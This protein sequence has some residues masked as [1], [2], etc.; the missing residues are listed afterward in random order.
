[1]GEWNTVVPRFRRRAAACYPLRTRATLKLT[2][3]KYFPCLVTDMPDNDDSSDDSMV[4]ALSDAVTTAGGTSSGTDA[5]E[6]PFIERNTPNPVE[7][8]G[9]EGVEKLYPASRGASTPNASDWMA[10]T[11]IQAKANIV[12]FTEH[13]EHFYPPCTWDFMTNEMSWHT[14][15][16]TTEE[17]RKCG[18]RYCSQDREVPFLQAY[19]ALF[20]AKSLALECNTL[21]PKRPRTCGQEFRW[22]V[23]W[24][25]KRAYLYNDHII[26]G[27]INDVQWE[28]SF[29][30]RGSAVPYT[31]KECITSLAERWHCYWH[32]GDVPSKS[33]V[34]DLTEIDTTPICND[35][36]SERARK[37]R[38][39][40]QSRHVSRGG[41]ALRRR[42]QDD[43]QWQVFPLLLKPAPLDEDYVPCLRTSLASR[44]ACAVTSLR[45][46]VSAVAQNTNTNE[47]I[48]QYPDNP[49]RGQEPKVKVEPRDEDVHAIVPSV[50]EVIPIAEP[51]KED[52]FIDLEDE[53]ES[54]ES[55]EIKHGAHNQLQQA[56]LQENVKPLTHRLVDGYNAEIDVGPYHMITEQ[57]DDPADDPRG[58]NDPGGGRNQPLNM[59]RNQFGNHVADTDSEYAKAKEMSCQKRPAT[60][61]EYAPAKEAAGPIPNHGG[62]ASGSW[63]QFPKREP[64]TT[65]VDASPTV[66]RGMIRPVCP[67]YLALY[68]HHDSGSHWESHCKA[69]LASVGFEQ[70]LDW[71]STFRHPD[72]N[73]F[74]VVYVD[75]FK[76]SCPKYKLQISWDL[77]AQGITSVK[78]ERPGPEPALNPFPPSITYQCPAG[79]PYS[80]GGLSIHCHWRKKCC[81]H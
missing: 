51:D 48:K 17:L 50:G 13:E 61:L 21:N 75:D 8:I 11:V 38:I 46:G 22:P 66:E 10:P 3:S 15:W 44:T 74:L 52:D 53:P 65:C 26:N 9:K 36:K 60:K 63:V 59:E 14:L 45:G 29:L 69:H 12:H 33:E 73:I 30:R 77:L 80:T 49:S 79:Y 54:I 58:D 40:T 4:G 7:D 47:G 18:I 72:H 78:P 32:I 81:F 1:M 56:A 37:D 42:V 57:R 70:I 71:R 34:H 55:P 28:E 16:Y 31:R 2:G 20:R 25:D 62:G 19:R 35:A 23:I 6:D 39:K 68:C 5:T 43:L 67:L 27:A 64:S 41:N 24:K 76:L